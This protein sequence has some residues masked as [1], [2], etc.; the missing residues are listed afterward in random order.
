MLLI[1]PMQNWLKV[2]IRAGEKRYSQPRDSVGQGVVGS[3]CRPVWFIGE[4]GN[5]RKRQEMKFKGRPPSVGGG[6]TEKL[7]DRAGL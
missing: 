3:A 7:T 1:P 6:N 2:P 4:L 5:E